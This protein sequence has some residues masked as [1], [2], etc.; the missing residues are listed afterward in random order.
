M[1]R[2]P[3]I[4]RILR[5]NKVENFKIHCVFNNGES[6]IID[7]KPIFKEWGIENKRED[8]RHPLLDKEIF[9]TVQLTD[10]TLNWEA[11]RK[12]ISLKSG[13][14]FDAA[15]DLDPIVLFEKSIVDEAQKKEYSIGS[16]VKSARQKAGMTQEELAKKSGTTRHY[17]SRIE[18]DRSDIEV[19]TLRKIIEIGLNRKLDISIL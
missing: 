5:I 6:R 3:A 18:N 4:P 19:G 11:I 1:R 8:F 9:K 12:E 16:I 2:K 10:N 7:F 17:I 14:T 13:K 15:F